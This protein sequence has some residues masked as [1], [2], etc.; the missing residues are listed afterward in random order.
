VWESTAET[1]YLVVPMRPA[2]C[3]GWSEDRLATLITRDAMIGTG[4]VPAPD[5]AAP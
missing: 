2:G 3:D 4:L 5:G 1:R